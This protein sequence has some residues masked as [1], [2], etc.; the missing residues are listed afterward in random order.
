MFMAIEAGG[1]P[2]EVIAGAP[3]ARYGSRVTFR[4]E[5]D[6]HALAE[7]FGHA[8]HPWGTPTWIGF[9]VRPDG[10]ARSKPYHRLSTLDDRF[11][12][13]AGL[14]SGFRPVMAALDDDQIEL[15]LRFGGEMPWDRY[16]AACT[17]PLVITPTT[18]D[19]HPRPVGQAFCLSLKWTRGELTAI[20]V[21]ADHRALPDDRTIQQHWTRQMDDL[22][23][24]AYERALAAVRSIGRRGTAW[25]AM[26]AWAFERDGDRHR[27][28]SLRLGLG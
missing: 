22:D 23:R 5:R 2:F 17:A 8:A 1:V 3:S 19:P 28:A 24:C 4:A 21:F 9:R 6:P 15:Y 14:P 11:T 27:A 10:T 16:V 25:H 12:L 7:V 18:F 13:P 20:T 26:L